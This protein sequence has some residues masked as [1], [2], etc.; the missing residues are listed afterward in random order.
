VPPAADDGAIR[1]SDAE[2]NA[3]A[4]RINAFFA[5]GRLDLDETLERLD[6]VYA[7]KTDAELSRV[8]ADLPAPT[9]RP[10]AMPRRRRDLSADVERAAAL[11]AP[12]LVCTAVW[13]MTGHGNFW[14]EWVWLA[15]GVGALQRLRHRHRAR[16]SA[17]PALAGPT[18][19]GAAVLTVV[20]IA[21]VGPAGGLEDLVARR[22]PLHGGRRMAV[23]P[24]LAAATFTSP[25][26]AIDFAAGLAA[27]ARHAGLEVRV[28]VHTGELSQLGAEL[29]GIAV[30]V[31]RALCTVARPG[32]VLASSSVREL[33]PGAED[34]FVDHGIQEVASLPGRWHLYA[35]VR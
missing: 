25:R 31:G 26:A 13:A 18:G 14:P 30:Y 34:R 8:F 11:V 27:D 23:E 9:P 20:F 5:E 4:E 22:L 3:A 35:V 24:A 12:G 15:T 16:A 28:G 2:R 32:E 29:D 21:A 7:A 33:C 1:L 10:P 6:Q 19:P 17:P